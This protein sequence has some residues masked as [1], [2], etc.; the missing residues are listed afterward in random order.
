MLFYSSIFIFQ[1]CDALF[2]AESIIPLDLL[3]KRLIVGKPLLVK[4]TPPLLHCYCIHSFDLAS[5]SWNL[6]WWNCM[7]LCAW[8]N[9]DRSFVY[10]YSSWGE[11]GL[12]V[13][14]TAWHWTGASRG[15]TVI[16]RMTRYRVTVR[17]TCAGRHVRCRRCSKPE[18]TTRWSCKDARRRRAINV[19][20]AW[21]TLCHAKFQPR[22]TSG[23]LSSVSGAYADHQPTIAYNRD[24]S[25]IR[26]TSFF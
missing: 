4:V 2:S 25:P 12:R 19:A 22:A 9:H 24:R 16:C 10:R 20:L 7:V 21:R 5:I 6:R 23:L 14:S 15:G 8:N 1:S 13:R 26:Y 11:I 17:R 18:T 3:L